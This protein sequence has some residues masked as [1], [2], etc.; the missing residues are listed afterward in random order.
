MDKY[1]INYSDNALRDLRDIYKYIA[2]ELKEPGTAFAYLIHS[3]LKTKLWS[4]NRGQIVECIKCQFFIF[5]YISGSYC[6]AYQ[7]SSFQSSLPQAKEQ[8]I[9]L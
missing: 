1:L 4:G 7:V 8:D 2:F 5:F 6:S 9:S 3:L